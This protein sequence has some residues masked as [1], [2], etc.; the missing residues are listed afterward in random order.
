MCVHVSRTD[1]ILDGGEV[2]LA[3]TTSR[4]ELMVTATFG[5]WVRNVKLDDFKLAGCYG[6]DSF[7][8]VSE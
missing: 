5:S 6:S 1:F 2:A 3:A 7:Q 8:R 4:M